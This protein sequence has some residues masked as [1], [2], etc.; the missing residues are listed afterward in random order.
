MN[1][2]RLRWSTTIKD[3]VSA[4]SAA[5][6]D[7]DAAVIIRFQMGALATN[8]QPRPPMSLHHYCCSLPDERN[9]KAAISVSEYWQQM[10]LRLATYSLY[11]ATALYVQRGHATVTERASRRNTPVNTARTPCRPI[12]ARSFQAMKV[13]FL[14]PS[15]PTYRTPSQCMVKPWLSIVHC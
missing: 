10:P 4:E 1:P 12:R 2:V 5:S 6:P 3:T 7:M 14:L 8:Q 15:S 9:L 13:E 11:V